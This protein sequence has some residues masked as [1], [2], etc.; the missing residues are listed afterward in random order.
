[1]EI[2]VIMYRVLSVGDLVYIF[3]KL[4]FSSGRGRYYFLFFL[5]RGEDSFRDDLFF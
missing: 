1:M 4:R 3:F 5:R 2:L